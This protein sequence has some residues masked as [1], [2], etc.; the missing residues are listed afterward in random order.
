MLKRS[1]KAPRDIN[2]LASFILYQAIDEEIPNPEKE[3][4]N[5]NPASVTPGHKGGRKSRIARV[6][7]LS[8][9]RRKEI[10]RKAAKA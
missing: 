2:K 10:A 7:A 8:L 3:P 5:K 4:E 9:K 1:S 6:K